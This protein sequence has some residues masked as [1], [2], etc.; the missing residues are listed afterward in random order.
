[1]MTI[2]KSK[3]LE[4]DTVI[5]PACMAKPA[6]ATATCCCGTRS[7]RWRRNLLV[8][9][10]RQKGSEF[11][12]TDRLRHPCAAWKA[13]RGRNETERLL[14]VAATRAIRRLHLVGVATA[15]DRKR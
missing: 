11:G 9:P 7:C 10:M 8:A 6:V 14:Y 15:D 12:R 2:H 1:M 13:E 4:F 3:G 5:L